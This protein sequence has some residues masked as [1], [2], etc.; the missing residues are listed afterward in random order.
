MDEDTRQTV[1]NLL[2]TFTAPELYVALCMFGLRTHTA[3]MSK[4]DMAQRIAAAGRGVYD[5]RQTLA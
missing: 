3:A 1:T 5:V 4:R 2:Q